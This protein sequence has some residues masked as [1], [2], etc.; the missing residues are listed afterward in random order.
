MTLNPSPKQFTPSPFQDDAPDGSGSHKE[1][2]EEAL[3]RWSRKAKRAHSE[4]NL[5]T[6]PLGFRPEVSPEHIALELVMCCLMAVALY[7]LFMTA[8]RLSNKVPTVSEVAVY[9]ASTV[10]PCHPFLMLKQEPA[11]SNGSSQASSS[12]NSSS[13]VRG[14]NFSRSLGPPSPPP[15]SVTDGSSS[16]N[17][18]I[19]GSGASPPAPS[20]HLR[21]SLLTDPSLTAAEVASITRLATAAADAIDDSLPA[22]GPATAAAA[23]AHAMPLPGSAGRWKLADEYSG[24]QAMGVMYSNLDAMTAPVVRPPDSPWLTLLGLLGVTIVGLFE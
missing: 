20:G 4:R 18:S 7:L 9:D 6:T 1:L 2:I 12:S 11:A 10:A 23:S 15:G 22:G 5:R 24:M 3:R 21:R 16:G 8:T 13:S 14:G 19:T 17:S